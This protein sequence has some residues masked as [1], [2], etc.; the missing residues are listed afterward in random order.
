VPDG[1]GHRTDFSWKK[2][3]KFF[4]SRLDNKLTGQP[5][6]QINRSY[7]SG[8]SADANDPVTCAAHPRCAAAVEAPLKGDATAELINAGVLELA[9]TSRG[10]L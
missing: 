2:S 8:S 10:W 9:S 6:G 3:A 5:G 4:E 7:L 1:A